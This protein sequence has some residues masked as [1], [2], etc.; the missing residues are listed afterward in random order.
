MRVVNTVPAWLETTV[1]SNVF[2]ASAEYFSPT[3]SAFRRQI[4][5]SI[6]PGRV[7][8]RISRG[9]KSVGRV[10]HS[11]SGIHYE[12]TMGEAYGSMGDDLRRRGF[13]GSSR[14]REGCSGSWN[15]SRS[16]RRGAK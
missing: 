4:G 11:W 6:V 13:P 9:N 16:S 1:T 3:D 12:T 14:R 8:N 7:L 5:T 2:Q 15:R 10:S